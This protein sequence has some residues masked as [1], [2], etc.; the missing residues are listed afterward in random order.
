MKDL[1]GHTAGGRKKL[2]DKS[3]SKG[4]LDI[5]RERVRG[6]NKS[7]VNVPFELEELERG[8]PEDLPSMRTMNDEK[9]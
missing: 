8:G 3:M 1:L 9:F 2:G 6:D 5:V 4:G 7:T